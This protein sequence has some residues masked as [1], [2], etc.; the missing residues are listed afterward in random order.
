MQC[1][2]KRIINIIQLLLNVRI[3]MLPI[4]ILSLQFIEMKN[5]IIFY[6]ILNFSDF[7]KDLILIYLQLMFEIF[8]VFTIIL[9]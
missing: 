8:A 1:T 7:R 5:L 9:K 3:S 4:I 2:V 6:N